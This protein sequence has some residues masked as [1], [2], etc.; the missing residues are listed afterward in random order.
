MHLINKEHKK[1]LS[2]HSGYRV[3]HNDDDEL[4]ISIIFNNEQ[5]TQKKT[6][7]TKK[8]KKDYEKYNIIGQVESRKTSYY[9][10]A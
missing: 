7:L 10:L 1:V 4:N 2:V 8:N 5:H 6:I 3:F 9:G